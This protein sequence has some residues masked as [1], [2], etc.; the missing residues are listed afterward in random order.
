MPTKVIPIL[1]GT[2]DRVVHAS[3]CVVSP[4]AEA[5]FSL[6][7]DSAS[8]FVA[9][10]PG[11]MSFVTTW[12]IVK[13][14]IQ[15]VSTDSRVFFSSWTSFD[16]ADFDNATFSAEVI[17]VNNHASNTYNIY[18]C[19]DPGG[20]NVIA[21]I[22]VAPS[23]GGRVFLESADLTAL[24]VASGACTLTA[25]LDQTSGANELQCWRLRLVINQVNPTKS[26]FQFPILDPLAISSQDLV[27]G[28]NRFIIGGDTGYIEETNCAYWKKIAD[29]WDATLM[30][31]VLETIGG[32]TAIIGSAGMYL[33][34]QDM[35]SGTNVIENVHTIANSGIELKNSSIDL[36]GL[37]DDR[38]FRLRSRQVASSA[39][40]TILYAATIF[41]K[42][43]GQIRRA[44]ATRG[45]STLDPQ[46]IDSGDFSAS[47]SVTYKNVATGSG[48]GGNTISIQY[49]S[50]VDMSA[51]S[52]LANSSAPFTAGSKEWST[53]IAFTLAAG[54]KYYRSVATGATPIPPATLLVQLV[55]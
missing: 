1:T 34:I 45:L 20:T 5:E 53:S 43:N 52:S 37:V 40:N 35:T 13:R 30:E 14:P 28:D 4:T 46:K 16:A 51:P 54:D 47:G 32:N 55:K 41:V 7:E 15:S 2:D 38:I 23:G 10:P 3:P 12:E 8:A 27:S 49:S 19:T 33:A 25:K 36:T 50:S 17:A 9:E 24:L 39:S 26:M 18:L 22:P 44:I 42:V 29:G 31:L 11:E 21:T 6:G 48:T